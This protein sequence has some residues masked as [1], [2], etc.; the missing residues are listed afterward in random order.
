MD[1]NG[2]FFGPFDA[3]KLNPV[4]N[5]VILTKVVVWTVLVQYAFGQTVTVPR[6][7]PSEGAN[8]A[9]QFRES[10]RELLREL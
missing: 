4:R 10:L 3:F 5:K 9:H 2:P 1:Q 8:A 6:P 7:L